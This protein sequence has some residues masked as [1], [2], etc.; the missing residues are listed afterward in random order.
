MLVPQG[1]DPLGD[2]V[3]DAVLKLSMQGKTQY[4][5]AELLGDRKTPATGIM[6]ATVKLLAVQGG[7][8]VAAGLDIVPRQP[9]CELIAGDAEARFVHNNREIFAAAAAGEAETLKPQTVE[10][11]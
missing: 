8:E 4:P 9:G 10:T 11:P 2:A 6:K 7:I 5:A 3:D 1:G